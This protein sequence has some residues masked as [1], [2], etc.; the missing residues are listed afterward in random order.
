MSFAGLQVHG[1]AFLGGGA[2]R[3][4]TASGNEKA[5]YPPRAGIS[6]DGADRSDRT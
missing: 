1:R 5:P 3:R 6:Y 4:V 2:C